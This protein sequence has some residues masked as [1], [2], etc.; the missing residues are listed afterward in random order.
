MFLNVIFIEKCAVFFEMLLAPLCFLF[1]DEI[2]GGQQT[3]E[4]CFAVF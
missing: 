2:M 4:R 1:G 3:T